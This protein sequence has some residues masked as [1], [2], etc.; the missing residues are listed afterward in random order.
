MLNELYQAATALRDRGVPIEEQHP[1]LTQMGKNDSLLVI[2]LA[3]NGSATHIEIEKPEIAG[4]LLRVCHS[5]Q[6]SSFPGFNIPTPLRDFSKTKNNKLKS[7]FK[8]LRKQHRDVAWVSRFIR[9][10]FVC[11]NPSRFTSDQSIKFERSTRELVGWLQDDFTTAG[12]ELTNFI[13]LLKFVSDARPKLSQF[14]AEVARLLVKGSKEVNAEQCWLM[15][16]WLFTNRKLPV[17]LQCQEE[18]RD[19]LRVADIRMGRLVNQQLLAIGARP[20]DSNS[21]SGAARSTARDAY[22][23]HPC[24]ITETFPD[25]K[26]TLLGNVRLFSNNTSEAPCFLRYGL[27][28]SK[29]FKVSKETAQ[30]MAGALLQLAS[31]D[32][33]NKT[34]RPIPSNREGKQDLLIAYL[35]DE[36]GAPDPYVELFGNKAANYDAPDFDAAAQP[37]LAALE[38]KVAANPNQLIR[39][40]AIAALDKA[41]KQVSLNRSFTV[42]EV[43]TAAKS[44]QEGAENCPH[45]TLPFYDKESKQTD[46]KGHTTPSPLEAAIV[47]NQVWSA[48]VNSGVRNSFERALTT[49]DAYDIFLGSGF[50]RKQKTRRLLQLLIVRLMTVFEKVGRLKA[51]RNFH[52]LNKNGRWH[53]VKAVALIG[54]SLNQLGHKHETFMN[55]S[56]Y[57]VGRLL[58][59][60]D[61]LHFHYCKWVR[62]PEK[63]R[64]EGKVDAPGELLG[65]AIFASALD[66]PKRALARLAERI[67]PYQ[68]WAKT[69]SGEEDW[70]G[71]WLLRM[72]AECE[73]QFYLSDLPS[74]MHDV[75]KAQL[76]LGYLADHPKSEP[77]ND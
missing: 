26:V 62:T 46:W 16:E 29:T 48:D 24:E 66:D 35:E 32:R 60:A 14:A 34:C 28:R 69:Y 40:I 54:I 55:E 68:G 76:L 72:M 38:G 58:A 18:D 49:G 51:T 7:R 71:R 10:L 74:G 42:S 33:L 39:L 15:A 63:K 45:V 41:N 47:A 52:V 59:I 73:R 17:Y 77:K 12:K 2:Q 44:W 27:G 70:K 57:Q 37:V 53:A 36:P 67:K 6:G 75:D 64:Q 25:P 20:F 3:P 61:S 65:N 43:M 1:S 50:V 5:S 21:R 23:G 8:E 9:K 13:R 19:H 4:K 30:R 56:T 31:D 11:S 22:T